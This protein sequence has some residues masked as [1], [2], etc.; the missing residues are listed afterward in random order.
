[1]VAGYR[2]GA[3][4]MVDITVGAFNGQIDKIDSSDHID[5][6]VAGIFTRPLEGLNLG[7]SY[8]SNLAASAFSDVI[9]QEEIESLVGGWS[10]YITYEFLDRFKV[11]GEYVLPSIASRPGKF[12]MKRM[13]RNAS[14]LHGTW[15]PGCNSRKI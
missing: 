12:M 9:L 10:A 6:F 3:N 13:W 2:F 1:M 11:I 5:G 7:A 15:K 14:R 8:T 4:E